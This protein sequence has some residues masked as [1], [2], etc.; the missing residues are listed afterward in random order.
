MSNQK[1]ILPIFILVALVQLYVPAKM[2]WEQ[3]GILEN[4]VVFKFKTA[5]VDP[6]DPFRGKFIVL[7]FEDT[8]VEVENEMDW[9][10]G[11]NVYVHLKTAH[12][13]F[14]KIKSVS[15]QKPAEDEDFLMAQVHFAT[16]DGSHR[17]IVDYPFD[18]FYMEE[19]KAYEA[20]QTYRQSQQD[21]SKITYALVSVKNGEAVL[22]DVLIDGVSIAEI[23]KANQ[24]ENR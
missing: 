5:P 2:I 1:V 14:A 20:E 13:G 17:V 16:E 12:D 7:S 11:E 3:E 6:S 4:G 15:K 19:S 23:V 8:S 9:T 21:T 22:R 10:R 18:R 24:Q